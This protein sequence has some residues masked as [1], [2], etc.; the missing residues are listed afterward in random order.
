[1]VKDSFIIKV[2]GMRD[3]NN[4]RD[5][6]ALGIDWMGF[7]FYPKSQR[8]VNQLPAYLP[9]SAKRVGVFVN[10]S[11]ESILEKIEMFQLDIVQLHGDESPEFCSQLAQRN[12]QIMRAFGIADSFPSKR[13]AEYEEYCYYF[14]FDTQ[15]FA[16]GGS[17]RKFNWD[18]LQNYQGNTP[19]L[20]SGGIGPDDVQAIGEFEHHKCVGIDINS[21]FELSPANKNIQ[22]I[23][24]F[25]KSLKQ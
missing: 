16:Y 12:I 2:C 8:Y 4:I 14:L 19:F 24:Q 7:I 22:S 15:T 10:E 21:K 23:Q 1:M 17:G 9:N 5:V 3:A 13:I 11:H 6:E 18:I 25:I 20:L